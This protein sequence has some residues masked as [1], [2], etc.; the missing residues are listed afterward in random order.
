MFVHNLLKPRRRLVKDVVSEESTGDGTTTLP[1]NVLLLGERQSGR[2]SVGN[3]LIGG[4]VFHTGPSFGGVSVTSHPQRVCRIFPR[5]FRR[6][7]AESHLLLRV[8]DMPPAQPRPQEVH[9]LCP[10]GVHVI[11]MVVR[12]DLI[13][14]ETQ[15][16]RDAESLFGPDWFKHSLLVL[17]HADRLKEAGIDPSLF[18]TQ[19]ADWLRA[20][21]D[22]AVGGVLFVDSGSDWPSLTGEPIRERVLS[23]S[24]RNH[25][26]TLPVIGLDTEDGI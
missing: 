8:L 6:N 12:A 25:H 4:A 7:G 5:Y 17:T 2:S 13:S 14:E 23:L 20:L 11:V 15:V 1:L 26:Q 21:A 16:E 18:L 10:E 9:A 3:A 22:R 24:A 19:A